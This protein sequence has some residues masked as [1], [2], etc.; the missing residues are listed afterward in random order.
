MM[1]EEAAHPLANRQT[2]E[3]AKQIN[4]WIDVYKAPHHGTNHTAEPEA[5]SIFRPRLAI[6]TNAMEWLSNYDTIDNLRRANPSVEI[7]LTD[8]DIVVDLT[9]EGD[10]YE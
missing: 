9:E 4:R 2:T 6:I 8:E 3:T 10:I 1:D 5:L 7:R